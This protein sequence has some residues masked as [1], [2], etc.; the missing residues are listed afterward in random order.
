MVGQ[1]RRLSEPLEW[2]RGGRVAVAL[3]AL[4]LL[5]GVCAVVVIGLTGAPST[6]EGCVEV[7]FASTTGGVDLHVCGARAREM[8]ASPERSLLVATRG[9]LRAACGRAGL[10]YRGS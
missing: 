9:E 5:A 6:R 1:Q 2:T 3:V 10:P 4:A 8:C 7:S